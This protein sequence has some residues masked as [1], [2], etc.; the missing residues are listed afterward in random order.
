MIRGV[1]VSHVTAASSRRVVVVLNVAVEPGT[2]AEMADGIKA[3]KTALA[4]G[5][6][7]VLAELVREAQRAHTSPV[8]T[9]EK[10]GA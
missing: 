2:S 6:T 10:G 3:T 1:A 9:D 7:D 4:E 5:L 8:S